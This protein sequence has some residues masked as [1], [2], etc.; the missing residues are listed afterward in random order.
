MYLKLAEWLVWRVVKKEWNL[1]TG[2]DKRV[3]RRLVHTFV[4]SI[5]ED[6]RKKSEYNTTEAEVIFNRL[7]RLYD[8][9]P[10]FNEA[11]ARADAL[12]LGER[13]VKL[14]DGD[15][16][17]PKLTQQQEI[18]LYFQKNKRMPPVHWDGKL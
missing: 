16:V 12:K 9:G 15:V 1:I 4:F 11:R 3:V 2:D 18:A 10:A 6:I 7:D 14:P 8:P 13:P 17:I 5:P